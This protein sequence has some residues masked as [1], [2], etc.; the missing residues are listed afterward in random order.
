MSSQAVGTPLGGGRNASRYQH[1]VLAALD[2]V[3]PS[4]GWATFGLLIMTLLIVGESVES[5]EWVDSAGLVTLLLWSSVV[6]LALAKV[7]TSWILLIPA[8]IVI[9]ALSLMWIA[10]GSVEGA[11]TAERIRETAQR[12]DV[13]WDAASGGGISTDLLP[14]LIMLLTISWVVGF[15]SSWFIFRRNNVW[16]AVVLLGSAILTNLSFLPE[17]FIPRFF[18]FVFFAMLLVVR[19]SIIQKHEAWRRINIKFNASSGWLTLHAT[20]WLSV[21]VILLAVLLPMRVYTNETV[22][23]IWSIGRSPI[24]TAEDFFARLFA[25]LPSKKDHP[26]RLF[27]KWLPF[28]GSIS[29]G[30]EPVG[31]ATSDYPS[32]WLSQTY[33]YYSSKGWIATDTDLLEIGPDILPPPTT[34]NLKREPKDQVMQL[35][36]ATDKILIGGGYSW[37]SHGGTVESL[38]PRKFVISMSDTSE[39]GFLPD[40]I[41]GL[42]TEIRQDMHAHK[43]SDAYRELTQ[44]LPPDLLVLEVKADQ[45]GF[46]SSIVLQRKAPTTP[47]LVAWNFSNRIQEH[48]AY[49][50][51]SHVSVA[52]DDDLREAPTEYSGFVTDHYLQLPPT[53]PQ[54]VKDLAERVTTGLDNPL[55]K[56]VAIQEYLRSPEFT[57][58]LEIEPPPSEMDGVEWFLFE[59]KTGYSDYY[60]SA[61]A[62]MLRAVGVPARMAAGY[63]PGELTEE[64]YR[65]I[66]DWDSHGWVQAYFPNYGWIDFEPTPNWPEHQRV[67]APV[68]AEE[69]GADFTGEGSEDIDPFLDEFDLLDE[70]RGAG[71]RG[72]GGVISGIDFTK[73]LVPIAA[74][75]GSAGVLWL[76]LSFIWNFGLGPLGPEAKLYAKLT[77][78]GWLA[79]VG[80]RRDQTPIEYGR[81]ISDT[82]P[83]V[84][85][86]AEK[87][88]TSYAVHRYGNRTSTE[89]SVQE[90]ADAWKS[91]RL[92]LVARVFERLIPL[93]GRV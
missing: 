89:E 12:L 71:V 6:G 37:I 35:G 82:L 43:A 93:S 15:L 59:S 19:M 46:M 74:A 17:S 45:S 86:G 34:D 38:A 32:Y 7:R 52:T 58:S 61:M 8:G 36:F 83:S 64:G 26:G 68:L 28:I 62:V 2:R 20:L 66:R 88:T 4:Q 30:G 10:V 53:V 48:Q 85:E 77:R 40:D 25:S 22:A 72:A 90:I 33:N 42:A 87:I 16:I 13:W 56:A 5:A 11:N 1:P 31:W 60:G 84:S 21:L 65:V 92:R 57:Y 14:F 3:T 50:T 63:A 79:G 67:P 44:R 23:Q 27:G 70:L 78:L 49:R 24:A 73:Y 81:L 55:D 41:Q 39:D 29:F 75:L 47:D 51:I 69:L 91:I 76:V 9:G 54:R 18:L 80:R